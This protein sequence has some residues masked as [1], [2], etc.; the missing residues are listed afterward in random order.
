ME[1]RPARERAS[2]ADLIGHLYD[3]ALDPARYEELL[4]VWEARIGKTRPAGIDQGRVFTDPEIEAHFERADLVLDRARP[5]PD[6]RDALLAEFRTAAA[7]I[8][9]RSLRI[10][11]ANPAAESWLDMTT[12]SDL[13][14]LPLDADAREHLDHMLRRAFAG[15]GPRTLQI[16][17]RSARR[18]GVTLLQVRLLPGVDPFALVVTSE[19]EWPRTLDAILTEAFGLS[20]SEI[21][22]IRGLVEASTIK[23]IAERR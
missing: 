8:V 4:D 15:R 1:R 5:Q 19:L 10:S 9:D 21:M 3:V 12:G 11:R 20:P 22:V 13:S 14:S 18:H 16:R 17:A 7:F 6:A 2:R 23:E